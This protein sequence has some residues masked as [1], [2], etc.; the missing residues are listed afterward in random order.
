MARHKSH[1][2]NGGCVV[3]MAARRGR[4]RQSVVLLACWRVGMRQST[5]RSTALRSAKKC[6]IYSDSNL[7]HDGT[8]RC[9]RTPQTDSHIRRS[10][11]EG[12][13]RRTSVQAYGCASQKSAVVLSGHGQS[14]AS[15]SNQD[16]DSLPKIQAPRLP[17]PALPC[18]L[19]LPR[20][21][22]KRARRR[23]ALAQGTA[24]A[25]PRPYF[26]ARMLLLTLI[27]SRRISWW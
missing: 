7:L 25:P 3:R 17:V 22:H 12:S 15:I 1:R 23:S 6:E 18:A 16:G 20:G 14:Q 13:S 9:E 10:V 21:R 26:F 19:P 2:G 8:M 24:A 27:S 4:Q 11:R 5:N